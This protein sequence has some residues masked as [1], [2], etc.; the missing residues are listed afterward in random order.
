M[1][2][3]F[4]W[5]AA[6]ESVAV[7]VKVDGKTEKYQVGT[8]DYAEARQEVVRTLNEGFRRHGAVLALVK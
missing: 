1:A 5:D 8:G 4:N 2:F 6:P 3:A 7:F